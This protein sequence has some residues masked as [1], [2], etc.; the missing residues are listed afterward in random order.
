MSEAVELK[1]YIYRSSLRPE[2]YLY[3]RERD[4]FSI[5]P[6]AVL[7]YFGTPEYSMLLPLNHQTRLARAD[8]AEVI[9]KLQQ[10]GFY[11]QMPTNR[12]VEAE[13]EQMLAG[14]TETLS[15]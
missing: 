8:S 1:S 7:D 5:L 14:H 4:E 3:L 15:H 12:T 11:L 6:E 13:I 9:Q 2:L 10:Q